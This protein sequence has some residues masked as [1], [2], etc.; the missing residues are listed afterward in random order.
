M[1]RVCLSGGPCGG[2]SSARSALTEIFTDRGYKVLFC[3]ET[4]TELIMNG[5]V[6]GNDISI[7]EFQ[8]FV[9]D[10]QLAK[11]ELYNKIALLYD[12]DKVIILYDRGLCDQMAYISKDKFEKLLKNRNMTLSDAYAH[13]DCIL[14]LVTAADGAIEYYEWNDPSK[15]DCGN[16]AARSES[17]EEAIRKDKLTKNAW[18]GHPH[19]RIFDN[20]STFEDKK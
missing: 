9:L 3:P 10:K 15:K 17:P 12:I 5:I 8:E 2:K 18:I 13:Y 11:E 20:S 16:N 7:E 4:A 1:L 14:H 6:P 19:L